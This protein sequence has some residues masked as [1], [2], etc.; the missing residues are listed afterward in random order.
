LNFNKLL[1]RRRQLARA[2]GRRIEPGDVL[3][4]GGE[5]QGQPVGEMPVKA[6]LLA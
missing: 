6:A 4:E 2:P 1:V 5:R 3:R